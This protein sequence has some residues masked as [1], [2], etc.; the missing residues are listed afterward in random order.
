MQISVKID[1]LKPSASN[2]RSKHSKEDIQMMADS[3]TH[4]GI[5]NPPSVAKNGDGRYEVV[6]G[7]LRTLGAAK[8]GV[9]EITCIDVTALT[10]SERT[11]ISL[12]ENVDRRGMTA[13]QY[14]AA[15]NKLFKAGMPVE[16][17]GERFS[18]TEREVQQ[19]LAIGSLP[20][21]IL[22]LA[23]AE[24]IGDRTLQAL[25][26]AAG[27]DVVRYG[28]LTAKERPRDWEI[29]E[30]LAG[31][32]GM[33]MEKFALFDMELYTGPKITDLFADTD[34]VWLMDGEQF[35]NLQAAA[36]DAIL[37]GY[38]DKGWQLEQIDY[39]QGWAYE[40]VSKKKGGK[41]IWCKNEK[42]GEVEFHVG[43]K[44][45]NTSGKAPKAKGSAGKPE[46]KPE[47]SQAFDNFM[48]ETRHK[49]LQAF[50]V[51]NNRVGIE[52]ALAL[53]LK[54]ADNISFRSGGLK[55]SDTYSDSLHSGDD[56]IYVHDAYT[57]MLTELGIKEGHTWD[58]DLAK[59]V[60]KFDEYKTAQLVEWIVLTI[61]YN[62]NM[63]GKT[64]TDELGKGLEIIQVTNWKAD[65][66][67]WNGIKNK[68]TLL[69]IAKENSITVTKNAT[70]NSIRSVLKAKVPATWR[71]SW[72]FFGK[73]S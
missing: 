20:K 8:A 40:R 50:M 32:K 52:G 1:E 59:L 43:Y 60:L 5:I 38:D 26:I 71:P 13:M 30:W 61:T 15:F 9:K 45:I 62:W 73:V 10:P 70:M 55:L 34:E 47:T 46:A 56:F 66:A 14:Y 36:Y 12:A 68:D 58:V 28:K 29:Q 19:L 27:K 63:E 33:F 39:W 57:D 54:Q 31:D 51:Q 22:D 53:V 6:A 37:K 23:D 65:D 25:A 24:E 21:K 3:I 17:I 16:K 7:F 72:L 64:V 2:V 35:W 49:A 42:S 69:K 44:R 11:E 18:K 48:G 4:R 67:F 41:V